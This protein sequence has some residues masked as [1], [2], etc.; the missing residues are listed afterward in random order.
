MKQITLYNVMD[1]RTG[2]YHSVVKVKER[3]A[4]W[5]VPAVEED[6]EEEI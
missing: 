1:I 5:F 3:I 6:D 2:K 4:K